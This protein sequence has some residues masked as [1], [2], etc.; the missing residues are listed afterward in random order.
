MTLTPE[1]VMVLT[2]TNGSKNVISE[3]VFYTIM[4]NYLGR[5]SLKFSLQL[6]NEC[7]GGGDCLFCFFDVNFQLGRFLCSLLKSL[8][9]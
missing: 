3:D 6:S 8:N 1:S 2:I 9:A 4:Y 7:F 5:P